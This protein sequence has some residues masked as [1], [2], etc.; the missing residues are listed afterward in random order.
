[1]IRRSLGGFTNASVHGGN[2]HGVGGGGS[3]I[4]TFLVDSLVLLMS[5]LK[6]VFGMYLGGGVSD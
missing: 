1:M 4:E 5:L 3:V 2:I 6:S